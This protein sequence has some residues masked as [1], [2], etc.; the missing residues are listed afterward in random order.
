MSTLGRYR[1]QALR[2]QLS[3]WGGRAAII[4][5][6]LVIGIAGAFSTQSVAG[7]F[8]GIGLGA[9]GGFTLLWQ[10]ATARAIRLALE[11]WGGN[12]GLAVVDPAPLPGHMRWID[13]TDGK[14]G[15]GLAGAFAGA[16]GGVGHYTYTTGSGKDRE[17]HPYTLAWTQI[18]VRD[19]AAVSLG[20]R[21][22]GSGLFNGIVGALS[23]WREVE[24]ESVDFEK[25]F[26]LWV[27][28]ETDELEVRRFFTP[29]M[30]AR[31]LDNPPIGRLEIGDGLLC[32]SL[33]KHLLEPAALDR[34]AAELERWADAL[35][36]R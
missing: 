32:L 7:A 24:L 9:V 27:S 12:R 21:E 23:A 36:R 11:A 5:P 10:G 4:A 33:E 14:M 3:G 22:F 28:D 31:C 20:P 2:T 29:A 8:L 16:D 26:A 34:A 15:P 30:I 18:G 17:D 25:R 13:T 19:A 6:A 35:R 1:K